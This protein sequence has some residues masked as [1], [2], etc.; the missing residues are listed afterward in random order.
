MNPTDF[1]NALRNAITT[2]SVEKL[3]L[4]YMEAHRSDLGMRTIG[5]KDNNRGIIEVSG[6]PGR[7]LI[8]R[9]TNGIDAIL[10]KEFE[11]HQ[12]TPE[13]RSP[14]EAALAWLN[15]PQS[16][17]SAMTPV[18]RRAIAQQITIKILPGEGRN[19][20][21]IDIEDH[22]IGLTPEQ[23]PNTILS[24]N[25]S[26]KLQ[27]HYLA[28]TYG[29]GGSS[30]L[31]VSRFTII[32]SRYGNHP[33]VGF[34]IAQ[35]QDL[36]AEE[37]K[38]GKYVYLVQQNQVL[39]AE[40]ALDQFPSG[41]W[42][43]HIGYDLSNYP[44]PLGPNSIYGL[45][46]Q[47]LF[48]PIL[49]IWLDDQ[50]HNYRRVIKGSRNALN[51]ATDEGDE[52]RR[53]PRLSHKIPLFYISLGDYGNIGLEYW[54]LEQ[55]TTRE[56]IPIASF[57]NPQK[58]I[59]LTI[60]GQNHAEFSKTLIKKETDLPYLAQRLICHI[61]CN[62]L[63]PS[64]KRALFVSN[65]EEVRQGVV[66][67]LIQEEI[68]KALKSDDELIRLNNE[69]KDQNIRERDKESQEQIRNEVMHILQLQGLDV[70]PLA[71]RAI[72]SDNE[73][74]D[75]PPAHPSVPRPKPKLIGLH[76]PPTYI[77]LL[78]EQGK[79]IT[80]YPGQ[81][82]YIR[83]ETDAHN[84]YH[85]A[86]QLSQSRV[87]II[88]SNNKISLRGSTPLVD[89]RMRLIIE[90]GVDAVIREEGKL[91]IELSR[92]GLTTLSD[93]KD[94]IIVKKPE[95][96]PPQNRISFPLYEIYSVEPSDEKWLT[97]EWPKDFEKI[98]SSAIFTN[99]KLIIYYSEVFPK[100][101]QQLQK[102]EKRDIALTKSF[103]NRYEIWLIV[104]SLLIYQEQQNPTDSE[105][106]YGDSEEQKELY[107]RKERCRLATIASIIAAR[108]AQEVVLKNDSE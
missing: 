38:S 14:K 63:T 55:P 74:Q 49:P 34:T 44:S 33:I 39:K 16:G 84:H 77:R 89:G 6:D 80:F 31:A 20:R 4:G 19:L 5:G 45:L 64:A 40:L 85:N 100:F 41:T 3:L 23:M 88:L 10:E 13:C 73:K 105:E 79:A 26:N 51:G 11:S 96:T 95:I 87:N 56:T 53:G 48:D 94:F 97:L 98:A 27:K 54:L 108:Q 93:E 90:G 92:Q 22:G 2:Q 50:I 28:G 103:R 25:E 24:L 67:D 1:L 65:R 76:E 82:R 8:E 102:F 66:R 99:N 106:K 70:G 7:S 86:D 59:V 21:T 61:D 46:N 9:L 52:D 15:I 30:T 104:H 32:A 83:V 58:P 72:Q 62:S 57:V 60:N 18:E 71:G 107:E 42:I 43:R 68:I 47:V 69:A 36:P 29:Q 91:R 37:Y 78:W 17:L 12:G 81:R 75:S 35:F 101:A